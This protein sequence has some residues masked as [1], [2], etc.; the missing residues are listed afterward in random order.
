M[1][2]NNKK[3]KPNGETLIELLVALAIFGIFIGAISGLLVSGMQAQR[4]VLATQELLNQASYV[5]EYITRALRMAVKDTSSSCIAGVTKANYW[6]D[7]EDPSFPQ[8]GSGIRLLKSTASGDICQEFYLD[9]GNILKEKRSSDKKANFDTDLPLISSNI[10][11]I[12][13]KIKVS[14]DLFGNPPVAENPN[15]QPRVTIFLEL[16]GRETMGGRP[17]VRVQ[18]SVSQRSLDV[19]N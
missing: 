18:T 16:A 7:P 13:F 1:E 4:R 2:I 3:T 6:V 11:I 9:A 14:G 17:S 15:L 19:P 12:S 8:E 10:T 5:I